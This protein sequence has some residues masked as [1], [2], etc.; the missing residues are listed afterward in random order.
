V[1]GFGDLIGESPALAGLRARL[2]LVLARAREGSRLP[3]ILLLGE[4]GTGK[5]LVAQALHRAG[6]RAGRPF[7]GVNCAAIPHTLL[8]A[9]LFGFERGAFTDARHS[10][11]G[12]FQE[13]HGGTL[14]LDE[15]G[16][17]PIEIQAKLLTAV[18]EQTVR[19]LGTSRS[20]TVDVFLVSA[21]SV[22]LAEAVRARAFR[23]D[24]YYRLA[25]LPIT[26]PP[27]R[28][29]G[30]DVLILARHFLDRACADYG[31]A[32]KTLSPDAGDRLMAHAWPGNVRE[33]ANLMERACLLTDG[34][35]I[36]AEALE[37]PSSAAPSA[38]PSARLRSSAN[39]RDSLEHI[40]RQQIQD[41]LRRMHGNISRT[42]A[43]L[44]IPRNTLKYRLLKHGLDPGEGAGRPRRPKVTDQSPAPAT[45]DSPTL[46]SPFRTVTF[47]RLVGGPGRV[48]VADLA[49][50]L[51]LVASKIEAFGGQV[52]ASGPSWL[53]AAFGLDPAE[54][55]PSRAANAALALRRAF[56]RTRSEQRPLTGTVAL[57]T[58][59]CLV[60]QREGSTE[61]AP[62]ALPEIEAALARLLER[63]DPDAI[64]VSPTTALLLGRRFALGREAGADGVATRP[65]RLAGREWTGFG[66]GGRPLSPF[67]GRDRELR[68]VLELLGRVRTGYGQALGIAGEAG[69]GKSRLLF[70]LRNRLAVDLRDGAVSYW[71]GRCSAH[72]T[73]VPYLPIIDFLRSRW[74]IRDTD[75]PERVVERV[76]TELASLSMPVETTAP[77]LLRL[78]GV[79]HGTE[80]LAPLSAEAVRARTFE[81][82]GQ[83]LLGDS[84][85]RPVVLVVEDLHWIDQTSDA[86]LA[87]L[88]ENLGRLPI[89][90]L[91]SYRPGYRPRWQEQSVASQIA[92]APLPQTDGLALVRSVARRAGLA[93]EVEQAIVARG[94][95]NPFFLE[96]LTWAAVEPGHPPEP[97]AVPATVQDAIR[98]RLDRLS[99]E[100]RRCLAVASVLGRTFSR[101]L[102]VTVAP[103]DVSSALDDLRR[104]EFVHEISGSAEPVYTFRHVLTQEVTYATLDEQARKALHLSA[105]QTLEALHAGHL[106]AA[107]ADLAHH[108][109][110]SGNG[111]KAI[112]YLTRFAEQAAR[113]YALDDAHAA[114]GEALAHVER[115]PESAERDR[116]AVDVVVRQSLWLMH[117]G[118]F[119]ELLASLAEQRERAERLGDDP[120]VGW[121]DF[122]VGYASNQVGDRNQAEISTQRALDRAQRRGENILVGRCHFTLSLERFWT[123]RFADGIEHSR[124]ALSILTRDTDL[125]Y[126]GHSGW[127]LGLNA[128]CLGDFT[129]ALEASG[130]T[131]RLG[132]RWGEPRLQ[133]YAA[134]IAGWV[135]AARGDGATAVEAC[136]QALALAPDP[137]SKAV[138]DQWLGYVL[139]E[140]DRVAEGRLHFEE[141]I[142]RYAAFKFTALH[143]W[144]L[145]WH[146]EALVPLGEVDRARTAALE[147]RDLARRVGFA[148]GVAL[149]H[150]ALGR[151]LVAAGDRP[152]AAVE[153]R[154]ALNIFSST[155]ARYEQAR[156]LLDLA[157]LLHTA[158]RPEDARRHLAEARDHFVAVGVPAFV[159]RSNELARRTG[160]A[161]PPEP[162]AARPSPRT[163]LPLPE[164]DT[165]THPT[166]P[167]REPPDAIKLLGREPP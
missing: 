86:F 61:V 128:V 141:A 136:Q 42:A 146:S 120:L 46:L 34:E 78:L 72:G 83:L 149:A 143:G 29:R 13:A 155:G 154:A 79:S 163:M 63:A 23:E 7:V 21:T 165:G 40:E 122:M 73:G 148:Y 22:D 135:A 54:D 1:D 56:E 99:G 8:E 31:L 107:C 24:L 19:R 33:L 95:G 91:A 67:V 38:G 108:Y 114:F 30:A 137:L 35:S 132:E 28:E 57:H 48:G 44:G 92:L 156:T 110:R 39:L 50:A 147:A 158:G 161:L 117:T 64:V 104:R 116:L 151:A 129:L 58:V 81:T 115:L 152:T 80:A 55:A 36:N 15:V 102:L 124:H 98:T 134:W 18:S 89:M 94:D 77:Y 138:A 60:G 160:L 84:R 62:E 26:L 41:A 139:A 157:E 112:E 43:H 5:G 3:P 145:A 121:Y 140:D 12:L 113:T 10:K 123:G 88:I 70:E 37:L 75:E 2:R 76:R 133:S 100:A 16:L 162:P 4:T 144:A 166:P 17:L 109:A 6:P 118:Q 159:E 68:A 52:V 105:G 101:S 127:T 164:I 32:L 96:E 14:F 142:D 11:P 49:S 74:S 82:L 103:G 153:L 45:R 59:R 27:L 20:E 106:E 150:R 51:S 9:E 131:T 66:L 130:W 97:T 125:W 47:L 69:A 65:E 87:S 85:Q 93:G 167:V 71:E 126:F 111:R 25:V 53:D 119:P 90:V